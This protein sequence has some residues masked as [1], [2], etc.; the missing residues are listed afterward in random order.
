MT[1]LWHLHCKKQL[2]A[3]APG[4]ARSQ[5]PGQVVRVL[6]PRVHAEA[7]GGREAVRRVA[8]QEHAPLLPT[9]CTFS[10]FKSSI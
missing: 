10:G 4:R 7:A 1:F 9:P 2:V 3:Q 6:H 8:R 5:L